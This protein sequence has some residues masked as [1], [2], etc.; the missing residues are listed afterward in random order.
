[1]L[2]LGFVAFLEREVKIK[3]PKLF[4]II[5]IFKKVVFA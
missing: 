2:E 3:L 1:M 4:R 5:Y